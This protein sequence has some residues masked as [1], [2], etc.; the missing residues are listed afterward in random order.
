VHPTRPERLTGH[1]RPG[2][3]DLLGRR[4]PTF[5]RSEI[6]TNHPVSAPAPGAN[7]PAAPAAARPPF[8]PPRIEPLG[9]LNDLT[10]LGGS[11]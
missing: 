1:L 7:E 3:M 4:F 9:A 11:L 2:N 8:V 5:I 6:M 10:Q